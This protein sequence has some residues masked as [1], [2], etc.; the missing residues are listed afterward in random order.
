[1]T[2]QTGSSSRGGFWPGRA[3]EGAAGSRL[4]VA[5]VV[6]DT[7]ARDRRSSRLMS[8]SRLVAV[9]DFFTLI[10]AEPV[11]GRAKLSAGGIAGRTAGP[12]RYR[13]RTWASAGV[14]C[15]SRT[16]CPSTFHIEPGPDEAVGSAEFALVV[17][18]KS[19][20]T[21]L[22]DVVPRRRGTYR[23]E[24]VAALR[25][26][27]A[28]VLAAVD[29]LAVGHRGPGLSRH[30]TDRPLHDARPPRPP[31]HD[32]GPPFPPARDRQRV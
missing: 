30:S 5:G 13:S 29:H 17:P 4:A 23:F 31:E 32:R 22:Y 8:R 15:G 19:Q 24:Q 2:T 21:L 9:V 3:W 16:M 1:M 11:P 25:L 10:G 14:G 18:G 7:E 26:E 12:S 6:S 27:P 28:G 20:A